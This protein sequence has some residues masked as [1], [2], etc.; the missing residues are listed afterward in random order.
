M[1]F[2]NKRGIFVKKNAFYW[3]RDWIELSIHIRESD[4]FHV[5]SRT[6]RRNSMTDG[7]SSKDWFPWRSDIKWR[8]RTRQAVFSHKFR[9][10]QRT[11]KNTF[12]RNSSPALFE[13]VRKRNEFVSRCIDLKL[14]F[15]SNDKWEELVLLLSNNVSA[16][17]I[18]FSPKV[19]L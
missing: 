15:F 5:P 6:K 2:N 11:I 10:K 12:H 1:V 19:T 13:I 3:G 17:K 14:C 4:I 16:E 9:W 8:L 18:V 7:W